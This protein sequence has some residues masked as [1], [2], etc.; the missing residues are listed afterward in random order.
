M[1]KVVPLAVAGGVLVASG[2]VFGASQAMAKDVDVMVDGKPTQTRAYMGTVGDVLEDQGITL[3][4]KDI[5]APSVDTP[6]ADGQM[7]S[8]R[9]GRLLKI[10]KD[11]QPSE[12][13]S[14]ANTVAEALDELQVRAGSDVSASRDLAIGREGLA[15]TINTAK[16]F[17]VNAGGV[18]KPATSTKATVGEAL[19]DAGVGFDD[20]D[21]VT[22]EVNTA[23]TPGL[24]VDVVAV[25]TKEDK[26]DVTIPFRTIRKESSSLTK[27]ATEVKTAGVTGK[28][29]ETWS[30]RFENGKSVER[31]LVNSTTDKEA[32]DKVVLVGTKE[33]P[34]P[35]PTATK[36]TSSRS[37]SSKS[38]STPSKS[39]SSSKSKSSSAAGAAPAPAKSSSGKA[40]DLRRSAYWD[41][42]AKCES[43]NNW[44]IN[45][46]NGYYGG[47]Q[48]LTSTWLA[49]GGD[50]F[51]PRADKASREEQITV[52]NRVYDQ[53]GGSQWECKA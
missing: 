46:G 20:D 30:E 26:K 23:L 31:K 29:T 14:T 44:H 22:P 24:K 41:R 34:A 18:D 53:D 1:R 19:K 48:F 8:V 21:R 47:L 11:G 13:W 16:D 25:E 39:S 7:I 27:G 45:T 15:L 33:K 5:V 38:T 49:Y 36:S 2:G 10:T 32:V 43:T 50:D 35:K 37:T 28:K 6:V 9:Y 42:I 3:S 52:A 40:I 17:T 4:D 12:V 51:A